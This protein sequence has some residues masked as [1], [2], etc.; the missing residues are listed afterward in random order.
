MGES[1]IPVSSASPRFSSSPWKRCA[2]GM[3][4]DPRG[5]KDPMAGGPQNDGPWKR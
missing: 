2:K 4:N 3:A 1:T 5:S